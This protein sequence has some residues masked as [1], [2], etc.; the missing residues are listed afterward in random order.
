MTVLPKPRFSS[1]C[2]Q[3]GICIL[4]VFSPSAPAAQVDAAEVHFKR[5]LLTRQFGMNLN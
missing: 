5:A 2:L 1:R 4:Q 3:P